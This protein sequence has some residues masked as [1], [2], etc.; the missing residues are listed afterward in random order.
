MG[1]VRHACSI[2]GC[3]APRCWQPARRHWRCLSVPHHGGHA[4]CA[5]SLSWP[6]SPRSNRSESSPVGDAALTLSG[7]AA[8]EW[9]PRPRVQPGDEGH[10][11][12]WD[13]RHDDGSMKS[14]DRGVLRRQHPRVAKRRTEQASAF[15]RGDFRAACTPCRSMLRG[16]RVGLPEVPAVGNRRTSWRSLAGNRHGFASTTI[17]PRSFANA[18]DSNTGLRPTPPIL[19]I[20]R[21]AVGEG[22]ARS[23][24]PRH[25]AAPFE[26]AAFLRGARRCLR[27]RGWDAVYSPS[28]GPAVRKPRY[29]RL[30]RDGAS[31]LGCG[32]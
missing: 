11:V 12:R 21:P 18:S 26:A 4:L 27:A 9:R 19:I 23:P 1:P 20:V 24:R 7:A 25:V 6:I 29:E 14:A 3:L 2:V 32:A 30:D 5:V 8:R 10:A 16:G 17:R 15:R 22:V 28:A 13:G 31:R